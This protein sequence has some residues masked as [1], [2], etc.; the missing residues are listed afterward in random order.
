MLAREGNFDVSSFDL[1]LE[2]HLGGNVG[3]LGEGLMCTQQHR[4]S[5]FSCNK[6]C[7]RVRVKIK[8]GL[9]AH[10][11]C[12]DHTEGNVGVS[13]VL[14]SESAKRTLIEVV[15][16]VSESK[17]ALL[18]GGSCNLGVT[19][20]VFCEL[21]PCFEGALEEHDQNFSQ[22]RKRICAGSDDFDR[23]YVV[24]LFPVQRSNF[25]RGPLPK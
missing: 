17:A 1:V 7:V 4:G 3:N 21:L 14:L 19:A 12:I 9:L 15:C 2:P 24:P 5:A 16:W 23:I 11:L 10:Q 22:V 8:M 20:D 18:W 6:F 25:M 13:T